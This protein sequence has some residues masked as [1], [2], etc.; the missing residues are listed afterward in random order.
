MVAGDPWL[1]ALY[2]LGLCACA[3][4]AAIYSDRTQWTRLALVGGPLLVATLTVGFL[5]LR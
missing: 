2:L 1:H 5:Q 4:S 3:A